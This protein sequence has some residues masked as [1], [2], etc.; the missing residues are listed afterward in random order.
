MDFKL[1]NNI[2]EVKAWAIIEVDTEK[3][4]IKIDDYQI[5]FPGEYEKS[6]ILIE[7]KEYNNQL[8]YNLKIDSK[9]LLVIFEETFEIKEEILSFFGDVDVL[10]IKWTKDSVKMTENIEARVVI[11]F[12]ETKDIFLNTVGQ[13]L[14]EVSIY[15]YK[16]D[17]MD[18][19]IYV[20]LTNS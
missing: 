2:I 4:N 19:T 8:F 5:D 16:S 17:I 3:K 20:N 15:K 11:P 6:W 13:H 12:G 1:K 7:V 18:E 9:S 14:E 10:L